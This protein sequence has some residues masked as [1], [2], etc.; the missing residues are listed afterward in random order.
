MERSKCT[1]DRRSPRFAGLALVLL[2]TITL[3]SSACGHAHP[4]DT[5]LFKGCRAMCEHEGGEVD[6][7]FETEDSVLC[8]CKKPAPSPT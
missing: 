6:G 4:R 2:M 3:T 7:V 5:P 8:S 1:T